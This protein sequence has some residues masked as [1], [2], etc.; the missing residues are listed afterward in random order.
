VLCAGHADAQ[1]KNVH[2]L[3]AALRLYLADHQLPPVAPTLPDMHSS[4]ASYLALQGLYRSQYQHDLQ[5]FRECLSQVLSEIGLPEDSI[6]ANEVEGFV[7]NTN[8]VAVIKG[9]SLTSRREIGGE[10]QNEI[11]MSYCLGEGADAS[12]D[13]YGLDGW[14]VTFGLPLHLAFMASDQ[15]YQGQGRW[16]GTDPVSYE[17]DIKATTTHL[18]SLVKSSSELPT[19]VLQCVQEM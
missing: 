1:S 16:P 14:P 10:L 17:S 6:V 12:D 4:T 11:G 7:K 2:V 19:E 3:L 18:A 5:D 13:N 8:G 9:S 15:F